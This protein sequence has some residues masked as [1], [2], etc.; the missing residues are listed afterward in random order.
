[1]DRRSPVGDAWID[2]HRF[3]L[4]PSCQNNT[5]SEQTFVVEAGREY[6]GNP[7]AWTVWVKLSGSGCAKQQSSESQG[8]GH[9]PGQSDARRRPTRLYGI[10]SLGFGPATLI[11]RCAELPEPGDGAGVADKS[12]VF[13]LRLLA[14]RIKAL[15][16]EA[17]T[18]HVQIRELVAEHVPELLEQN[19][20]SPDSAAALLIAAGDNPERIRNEA[21]FAARAE[22]AGLSPRRE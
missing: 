21:S 22:R 13:T 20:V 7:Q 2:G 18:L 12:V 6:G 15:K 5:G 8:Q 9:Q 16:A 4:W 3:A 11:N 19:G 1:L 14:Q 17:Y 10:L